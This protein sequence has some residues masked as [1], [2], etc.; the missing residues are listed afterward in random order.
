M[1]SA[2]PITPNRLPSLDY[3]RGFFV[4]LMMVFHFC[5]V[6]ADYGYLGFDF[7]RDPFW[8]HSRTFIVSG[9][10]T[11]VGLSLVL[12]TQQGLNRKS[13]LKRLTLLILYAALVSIST[14][15]Q[16]GDRWVF[17]GILHF[18][19]V[20]SVLGLVV[21]HSTLFSLVGGLFII[22]AGLAFSF[23]FFD[24]PWLNWIGMMTH[25]PST[26]DY[27]PLFPWLGVVFVGIGLGRILF[28][29]PFKHLSVPLQWQTSSWPGKILSI[30]GRQAIHVYIIHVPLFIALIELYRWLFYS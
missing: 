26:N 13:Y 5:F 25:K 18:I 6:L 27:V 21:V 10:L 19:A 22:G 7:Y 9:F 23:P 24:H 3:A 15:I 8:L 20:A 17:F 4:V 1:N 2:R 28:I 29:G 14:Y 30:L 12:A 16:V 11:I